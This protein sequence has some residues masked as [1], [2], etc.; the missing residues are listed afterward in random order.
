[1]SQSI[2]PETVLR[3][4]YLNLKLVFCAS[5]IRLVT[6]VKNIRQEF[7][8]VQNGMYVIPERFF[9]SLQTLY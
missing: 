6:R 9:C 8:M 7:R 2:N 1:M 5:F 4:S 3:R